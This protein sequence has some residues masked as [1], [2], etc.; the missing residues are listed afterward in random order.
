M[1][2]DGDKTIAIDNQ[3][4]T[5]AIAWCNQRQM[6]NRKKYATATIDVVA[7]TASMGSKESH[8]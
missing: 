8:S 6:E 3:Q 7:V 2:V 5:Q 4:S 1:R